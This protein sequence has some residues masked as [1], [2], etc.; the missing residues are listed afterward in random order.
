[1]I[2][3]DNPGGTFQTTEGCREYSRADALNNASNQ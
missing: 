2:I 3:S 1:M